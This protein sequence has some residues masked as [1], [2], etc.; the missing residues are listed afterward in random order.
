MLIHGWLAGLSLA[1]KHVRTSISNAVAYAKQCFPM[2]KQPF[3]I[4]CTT[5]LM[6]G[7]FVFVLC[8][9]GNI[10][11]F[12][13]MSKILRVSGNVPCERKRVWHFT[14]LSFI[15]INLLLFA[16]DAL[17]LKVFYPVLSLLPQH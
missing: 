6:F 2:Q 11:W 16:F 3:R 12:T 10:F 7:T 17:D 4:R 14:E 13:E 5:Y 15:P 1:R 8:I 9:A